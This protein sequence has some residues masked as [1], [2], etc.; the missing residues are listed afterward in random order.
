MKAKELCKRYCYNLLSRIISLSPIKK[1]RIFFISFYGNAYSDNPKA[2]SEAL[3]QRYGNLFEYVWAFN[4][5][6][7]KSY[8]PSY[9]KLVKFQTIKMLF[10]MCTSKVWVS[11]FCLSKGTFKKNSQY[12]IH[13][14]H[15]DRGF[16]HCLLAVPNKTSFLFE[17]KHAD[18]MTVGSDFGENYVCRTA[19]RY[20]G[21]IIK[22]GCPRNDIFYKDTSFIESTIRKRYG[23]NKDDKILMYAPTFRERY[24]QKK[25]ETGLDFR[26]ILS[27]LNEVTGDNWKVLI[28]S[29]ISNSKYGINIDY[30]QNIISVTDYP[31]MNE[32]LK[33]SDILLSDYS[34]SIGD[35]CLSG[36][37][38]LLYQDDINEYT[39]CDRD[40]CINIDD[41]P[42]YRFSKAQDI[43]NFLKNYKL[44]NTSI[45]CEQIKAF[46]GVH[47][48]GRSSEVMADIIYSKTF[49]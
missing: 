27:I 44:Y 11:N 20:H 26:K 18:L 40:L 42:F 12:Y 13:T 34:S 23:L 6:A 32:L 38:C 39:D 21:E 10:Y 28:R 29:H 8:Y 43:Y 4:D 15:G 14:W 2:I 16:K 37:M 3:Y 5:K 17:S 45:N 7:D 24:K 25:Q 33:I 9:V 30:S 41:S 35:F 36:K 49:S 22:V 19:F 31:D 46:Y 1:N 48:S 47:E